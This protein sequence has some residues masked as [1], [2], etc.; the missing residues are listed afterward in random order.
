MEINKGPD[1]R[2]NDRRDG[3]IRRAMVRS[4]RMRV[5]LSPEQS[6]DSHQLSCATG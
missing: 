3:K 5:K 2:F 6:S 4:L 1:L